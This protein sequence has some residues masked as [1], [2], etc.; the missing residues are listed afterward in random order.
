LYYPARGIAVRLE[1]TVWMRP[2]GHVEILADYS[3][4]FI[5]QMKYNGVKESRRTRRVK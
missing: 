4:D 5:L 2:D 3:L 1:D